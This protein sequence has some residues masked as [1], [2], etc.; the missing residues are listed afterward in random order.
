MELTDRAGSSDQSGPGLR[1]VYHLIYLI[2]LSHLHI[3]LAAVSIS[4]H[5]EFYHI[6]ITVSWLHLCLLDITLIQGQSPFGQIT[7]LFF[8]F[9]I[10]FYL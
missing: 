10:F 2:Y 7:P 9:F 6:L 1:S 4:P 5:L 3:T 8:F